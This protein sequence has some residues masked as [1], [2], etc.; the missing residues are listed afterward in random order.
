MRGNPEP[1]LSLSKRCWQSLGQIYLFFIGL[2]GGIGGGGGGIAPGGNG[3][4]I[5]CGCAPIP[6]GIVVP[7]IIGSGTLFEIAGMERRYW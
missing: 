5:G 6:G 4:A 1:A 7:G 2:C 3:G